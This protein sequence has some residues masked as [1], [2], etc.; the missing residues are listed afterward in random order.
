M[1]RLSVAL[2]PFLLTGVDRLAFVERLRVVMVLV[3]L[4][5]TFPSI[6]LL[7]SLELGEAS[8]EMQS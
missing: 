7:T 5:L 3:T 4:G 1:I 6:D 8:D 2:A